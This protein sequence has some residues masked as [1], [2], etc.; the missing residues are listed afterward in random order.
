MNVIGEQVW[1]KKF[2]VGRITA[3]KEP[4]IITIQFSEGHDGSKNFLFP[5]AFEKYLI[6]GA[7]SLQ[8]AVTESLAQIRENEN[9]ERR[10]REEE[11]EKLLE[12]QRLA[13]L[14]AKRATAKKRT[15]AKKKN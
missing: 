5:D 4:N 15:P 11:A 2:G 6:F 12:G 14:E 1:H 13:I 10:Q 8:E 7:S 9:M 3:Q